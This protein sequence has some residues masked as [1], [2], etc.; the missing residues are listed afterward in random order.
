MDM[1]GVPGWRK[2]A[3][4]LQHS[5]RVNNP[6]WRLLNAV[7]SGLDSVARSTPPDSRFTESLLRLKL[8]W[9]NGPEACCNL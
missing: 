4:Y 6:F 2:T 9:P 1:T 8:R 5:L 7:L 3:P